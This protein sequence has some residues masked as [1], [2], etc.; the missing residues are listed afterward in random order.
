M[1]AVLLSLLGLLSLSSDA[2]ANC[3][4]VPRYSGQFRST[5]YDVSV[6]GE[7]VWTATGYG[8]QL[9]QATSEGPVLLDAV[10]IEGSTRVVA[11]GANGLAYAGSGT[12]IVVLRRNGAQIEIVRRAEAGAVIN[13]ILVTPTH[14]FVATRSG[15]G[16][17]DLID[18]TGPNRTNANLVTSRPNVTSLAFARNTVY[19][20]DG[21]ATVEMFNVSVPSLPQRVGSL[22]VLPRAAAVH[23][24]ADGFLFI[25]DDFGQ[26]TDIFTSTTRLSRIPYG[27]TSFATTNLGAFFV[28]GN[29]RTIRAIE[30]SDPSRPAELFERQLAPTG[31][32]ANAVFD[33]ARSGNTLYVAAGDAGLLTLDI[34]SL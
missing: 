23:A 30:L 18:P 16:H 9:L 31:G 32:T 5:I 1:K 17:F 10:A 20:A 19:A 21:D 15:I 13:D 6:D 8:A 24:T 26:N 22:D 4:L 27:A 11:T 29:D 14:L 33:M 25:S 7:Y 28:A 34:T 2:V 3:S 12:K